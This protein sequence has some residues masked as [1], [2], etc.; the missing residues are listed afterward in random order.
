[1]SNQ[2]YEAGEDGQSYYKLGFDVEVIWHSAKLTHVLEYLGVKY[3]TA[4]IDF[5]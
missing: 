5:N 4:D 1:L 2:N 3:T